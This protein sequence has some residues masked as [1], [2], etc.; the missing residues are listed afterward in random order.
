MTEPELEHVKVMR[1]EPGDVIVARVAP[2]TTWEDAQR[3]KDTLQVKF[4]GHEAMVTAG[5][6][7]DVLRRALEPEDY[8]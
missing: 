7:L 5:A 2:G 8:R 4:P 1:L 6:E 3:L